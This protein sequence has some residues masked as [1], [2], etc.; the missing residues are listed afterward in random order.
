LHKRYLPITIGVVILAIIAM[1]GYMR[2]AATEEMPRRILFDSAGGP[3]IFSHLAHDQLYGIDCATCHHE[4]KRPGNDP[5]QCG[6]CHPPEFTPLYV[7]MHTTYFTEEEHCARC[8]H[9]EFT[10]MVYDHDTHAENYT[11][12]CTDCHHDV[13]IEPVPQSC[14]DCHMDTGDP[15]MPSLMDAAHERCASCHQAEL[16]AGITDCTYCHTAI[17][18]AQ[19]EIP[20]AVTCSL[21]HAQPVEQLIP[22]RMS[23]F[24][25]GCMGCHENV[26]A[27][28]Y[29]DDACNQCHM[30]R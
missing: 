5:L 23:A 17:S 30:P 4:S 11:F 27:G 9:I 20:A 7:S 26:Q 8:H 12:G 19:G 21:C 22:T 16:D 15:A 10:G 14:G 2:P 28:P 29:A 6:L 1:V 24:H 13:D 3:V 18:A 25:D